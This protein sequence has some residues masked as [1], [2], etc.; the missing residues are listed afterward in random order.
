[1]TGLTAPHLPGGGAEA[2]TKGFVGNAATPP[3]ANGAGAGGTLTG[4]DVTN[5][6][7]AAA[8]D[9]ATQINAALATI[10]NWPQ[11]QP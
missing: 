3:M 5:L 2:Q 6:T 4:G 10:N 7:N 1:M 9:M 11:G 8:A